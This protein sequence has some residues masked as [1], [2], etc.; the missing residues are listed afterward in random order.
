MPTVK[1]AARRKP[2]NRTKPYGRTTYSGKAVDNRT[3]TALRWVAR[4][5]GVPVIVVQGSYTSELPNGGAEASRGTHDLG[6]V[7]DLHVRSL[8]RKQRIRL[9][10]YMKRAGFAAWYR[11][12]LW[13]NGTLVWGPHIHAV[14]RGHR[15]LAPLAAQQVTAYDNRLDGLV[16]RLRDRTWRPLVSRRWSH[17]RNAPVLGK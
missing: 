14:L 11:K 8:T 3:Y 16:T 15:N 17:R 2:V 9:V 6:G 7:V 1:H 13:Q 5:A 10:R 4:K 12:E